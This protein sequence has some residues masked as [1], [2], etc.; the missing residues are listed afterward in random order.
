MV[1]HDQAVEQRPTGAYLSLRILAVAFVVLALFS[2]LANLSTQEVSLVRYCDNLQQTMQRLE[3]IIRERNPMVDE[4]G[5]PYR[6]DEST[7]RKQRVFSQ[8]NTQRL[9]YLITAKL[10]F[11]LPRH[12]GEKTPAY[13][14]RVEG[15]IQNQCQ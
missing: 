6:A 11:L 8:Y 4:A 10:L 9:P 1:K 13:L 15:N 12:P 2:L 3:R 7:T 14:Q 5:Q